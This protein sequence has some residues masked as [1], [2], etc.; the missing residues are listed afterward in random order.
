MDTYRYWRDLTMQAHART[1]ADRCFDVNVSFDEMHAK[2]FRIVKRCL[3]IS[4]G[5]T[6]TASS[7][8]DLTP[9][10]DLPDSRSLRFNCPIS[11]G[12]ADPFSN[13]F[14]RN[15]RHGCPA[16]CQAFAVSGASESPCVSKSSPGK[17]WLAFWDSWEKHFLRLNAWADNPLMKQNYILPYVSAMK[18]QGCKALLLYDFPGTRSIDFCSS[19]QDAAPL[20]TIC[21]QE[22]GCLDLDSSASLN[23]GC[24]A[25][26]TTC[27]DNWPPPASW[28]KLAALGPSSISSC[29]WLIKE[30]AK[31]NANVCK[32]EVMR[33]HCFKTCGLCRCWD[34][35]DED[36]PDSLNITSCLA[37]NAPANCTKETTPYC[38]S[39]CGDCD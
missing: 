15:T 35:A 1:A 18:S 24:A 8:Q 16:G 39:T 31:R 10:C 32:D 25:S 34:A 5:T 4:L 2:A 12:C 36:I 29:E 26:C 20:Q 3:E 22:C 28:S 7:C 38:R 21:P 11:C 17:G 37:V 30:W 33:T 13:R 19:H 14:F 27:Q 23:A 6:L 9:Y